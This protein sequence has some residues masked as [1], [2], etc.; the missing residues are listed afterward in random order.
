MKG[1]K[2]CDR[3][4]AYIPTGHTK[5]VACGNDTEFFIASEMDKVEAIVFIDTMHTLERHI[6]RAWIA[7]ILAILMLVGTNVGWLLYEAQFMDV[8]TVYETVYEVDAGEQ[9]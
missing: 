9:S 6:K 5:C 7:A 8:M 3:C 2:F 4:G 1:A